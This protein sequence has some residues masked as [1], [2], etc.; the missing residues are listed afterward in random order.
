MQNLPKDKNEK[1]IED[2]LKEKIKIEFKVEKINL[3]YDINELVTLIRLNE[4]L[5][6]KKVF[7]E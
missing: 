6:A 1:E 4:K 3:A 7:L 2:F 5:I